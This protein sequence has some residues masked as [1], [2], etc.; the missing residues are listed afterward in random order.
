MDPVCAL[1]FIWHDQTGFF[2]LARK[3]EHGM[4]RQLYSKEQALA[5]LAGHDYFAPLARKT[6]GSKKKDVTDVG[7][8][9]WVDID[10]VDGLEQ[11]LARIPFRPSLIAASGVKGYWAYWKLSEPISS[12]RIE[13]WNRALAGLLEADHSW[14]KD[15][16]ARLPGSFRHE[17]GKFA[18]VVEFSAAAYDPGEFRFLPE[19]TTLASPRHDPSR[20]STTVGS[21]CRFPTVPKL[22]PAA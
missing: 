3:D 16:L 15:R 20:A 19:E 12:D 4:A 18:E 17:T 2:E 10:E 13:V 11:R 7:N 5:S 8:V 14:N 22:S 9:L 1:D 21:Y 6:R